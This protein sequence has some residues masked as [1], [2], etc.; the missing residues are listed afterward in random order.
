M[1]HTVTSKVASKASRLWC[2]GLWCRLAIVSKRDTGLLSLNVIKGHFCLWFSFLYQFICSCKFIIIET[3]VYD[4]AHGENA[5][6]SLITQSIDT[7]F[8]ISKTFISNATLK[9]AKNTQKIKQILSNNLKL[10]FYCLKV[11]NIP[12]TKIIVHIP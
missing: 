5:M 12:N 11:I 8:Y 2:Y 6:S 4:I 10:N 3:C 7:L 1:S 9:L